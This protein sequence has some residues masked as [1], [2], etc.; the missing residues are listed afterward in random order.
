MSN[1]RETR[2]EPNYELITL[3]LGGHLWWTSTRDPLD[4]AHRT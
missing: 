3:R 4:S 1:G 2:D